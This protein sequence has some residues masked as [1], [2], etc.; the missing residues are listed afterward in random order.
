MKTIENETKKFENVNY[1]LTLTEHSKTRASQR[2]INEEVIQ[3]AL[4]YGKEIFKQGLVFIA[5]QTKALPE[6]LSAKLRKKLNNLVLVLAGD[7]DSIITC[8]K[9]DHAIKYINRKIKFSA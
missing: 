8:Y 3:L 9:N 6:T 1:S 4:C 7:S 2:G 5:V